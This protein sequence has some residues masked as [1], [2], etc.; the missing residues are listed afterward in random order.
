MSFR[1]QR[2]ALLER[3]PEIESVS[4]RDLVG[5]A[6]AIEQQAVRRYAELVAHMEQRGE[7]A[8]AAACRVLHQHASQHAEA[9]PTWAAELGESLP[10]PEA[11][12]ALLPPELARSW[13]EMIDSALLTP[14]RAFAL[15]VDNRTRG[16][17]FYSYLAARATDERVRAEAERLGLDQ[18][19]RAAML[20]RFRRR[21][22]HDEHR[23]ARLPD[24]TVNSPQ[25]LAEV[26][27]QHEAAI[28][29][30]HRALAGRLRALGDEDSAALLEQSLPP[31]ATDGAPGAV[32][33]GDH[34]TRGRESVA[35]G[36]EDA[37][38][39]LATW[40]EGGPQAD[41]V[42]DTSAHLLVQAQKPLEAFSETLEAIMRTTE[43]ALFEQTAAAMSEVVARLARISLHAVQHAQAPSAHGA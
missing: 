20:R 17:A 16:F 40:A 43:G 41:S 29:Q 36:G 18:L 4:M 8:T 32:A 2:Q 22:Y 24:L 11:Y 34:V 42:S 31:V 23:P 35:E 1:S 30:Q 27:A 6:N 5:A 13:D 38:A 25:A 19:R 15:A 12:D 37:R 10:P 9:V 21:A 3:D 14:Y 39:L 7:A 26:L 33:A 28:A